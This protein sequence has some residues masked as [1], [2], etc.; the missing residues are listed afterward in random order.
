MSASSNAQGLPPRG[1][2]LGALAPGH[3]WSWGCLLAPGAPRSLC[4]GS[5]APSTP[6]TPPGCLPFHSPPPVR[7]VPCLPTTCSPRP[8][9]Y[10][11]PGRSLVP[12]RRCS[13]NCSVNWV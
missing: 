5:R 4:K 9:P 7:H 3:A 12:G 13:A 8:A 6:P 1:S 11:R 2:R 10:T